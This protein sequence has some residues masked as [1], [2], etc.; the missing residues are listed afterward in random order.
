MTLSL[1][2]FVTDFGVAT[3]VT[4][5]VLLIAYWFIRTIREAVKLQEEWRKRAERQGREVPKLALVLTVGGKPNPEGQ[6][7]LREAAVLNAFF[8]GLVIVY[9]YTAGVLTVTKGVNPPLPISIG[10]IVA[11]GVLAIGFLIVSRRFARWYE[12]E[13]K[14]LEEAPAQSEVI[15]PT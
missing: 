9:A 4:L 7:R 5:A 8:I 1:D 3:G 6:R 14:K 12:S 2:S 13:L 10:L 11:L 15:R